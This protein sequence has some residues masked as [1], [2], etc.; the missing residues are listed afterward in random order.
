MVVSP[1]TST[2][3][4]VV[5]DNNFNCKSTSGVIVLVTPAP[6]MSAGAN[7]TN[8]CLGT[9]VVISAGGANTYTWQPGNITSPSATLFPNA[10]TIYTAVGTNTT[11]GCT[12]TK[13]VSVSVFTLGLAV[14]SNTS[15]CIGGSVTLS[16]SGASNYSWTN[17][18]QGQFYSVS[19]NATTIYSVSAITPSAGINCPVSNTVQV[20]VNT[21]PTITAVP[22]RTQVCK[23]ETATLTAS[24]A[25]TYTWNTLQTN[26]SFTDKA[27]STTTQYNYTV[28]GTDA[29]GCVNTATVG[30][31]VSTCTGI[32]ELVAAGR[33]AVFPNPAKAEVFVQYAKDAS[34]SLVN[35][36]GQVIAVAQHIA[37]STTRFAI[38]QLPRGVYF[39]R[40]ENE[41]SGL[42]EK[43]IIE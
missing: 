16:A 9:S 38:D 24:G 12:K 22:N 20:I 27:T 4:Q 5:G 32:E 39:I 18:P 17:S 34:L 7:K 35:E 31:K 37:G 41:K 19:P 13:T 21:L 3:Y 43:V 14:S 36:I 29:N 10:S 40:L 15:V 33:L 8:I 25:Q 26:A 28:T 2:N 11:T 30:L 42:M 1:T 6:L 23:N